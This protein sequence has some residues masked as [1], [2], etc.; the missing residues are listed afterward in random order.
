MLQN[1]VYGAEEIGECMNIT[2]DLSTF[3]RCCRLPEL[4]L[5][6]EKKAIA[7]SC[8]RATIADQP[9]PFTEE[10]EEEMYECFQECYLNATNWLNADLKPD[11]NVIIAEYNEELKNFPQWKESIIRT[12]QTCIAND[13][14]KPEA[15]CKSGAFQFGNCLERNMF[16]NCPED[17]WQGTDEICVN[18]K[19]TFEKCMINSNKY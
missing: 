10:E 16:L 7:E 6:E 18:T 2:N 3:S 1:E 12:V 9:V 17:S 15:K 4:E 11:E 5:S 14:T 13:Y 8:H 19:R